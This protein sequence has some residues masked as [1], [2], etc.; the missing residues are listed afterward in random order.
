MTIGRLFLLTQLVILLNFISNNRA[1]DEQGHQII[2]FAIDGLA[3]QAASKLWMPFSQT[4]ASKGGM[5][6]TRARTVYSTESK[7]GWIS[8]IYGGAPADFGCLK[9]GKCTLP[10][11]VKDYDSIF[12][13]VE[14]QGYEVRIHS[15][16]SIISDVLQNRWVVMR[17]DPSTDAMMQ[18]SFL[19]HNMP[20]GKKRFLF[21][22]F[23]NVD[24]QGHTIG[25]NSDNY[26]YQV[27]CVDRMIQ[28]MTSKL[29]RR[30]P[31]RTTFVIV[32]DHGG[33]G[34]GHGQFDLQ[35]FQVPI[36]M[37]GYGIKREQNLF[38]NA[39]STLQVAPTI[40]YASGLMNVTPSY[41]SRPR[42]PNIYVH[43]PEHGLDMN[44]GM[45]LRSLDDDGNGQDHEFW[46][47]C[48][49]PQMASHDDQHLIN[50]FLIWLIFPFV[51]FF[52]LYTLHYL[53]YYTT[54]VG[55]NYSVHRNE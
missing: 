6:T 19:E 21:F 41:W 20:Q 8:I 44:D 49:L 40:L 43:P 48:P 38:Q 53:P 23:N 17:F 25:Y 54:L 33:S 39:I 46:Q 36:M 30:N 5:Y 50:A 34:F 15:E 12:D 13:V 32:S 16:H 22:H 31:Y 26:H 42:I 52:C 1:S 37:W 55:T 4:L 47:Y 3:G 51:L 45:L 14:Q 2:V 24:K 7:P 28:R 10:S 9:N 27:I 35:D 11:I 18:Y 29:W